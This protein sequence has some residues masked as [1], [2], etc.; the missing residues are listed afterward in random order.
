MQIDFDK[1]SWSIKP[2]GTWLS[3][4]CKDTC[5]PKEFVKGIK[6]KLYIAELKEKRKKRS[7][8]ANAYFWVLCG[9]LAAIL[10]LTTEEIYRQYIHS[11]GN[12]FEIIPMRDDAVEAWIK[13]WSDRGV[14]WICES[15]G[16]SKHEG[17]TNVVCYYGSSV[18]DTKQMSCLIDMVVDDCKTQGIETATPLEIAKLKARWSE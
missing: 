4:R 13:I 1:A 15:L 3:I 18:Y 10:R 9:K 11:I 2:D 6:D 5:K 16:K 8:D 17:Y 12:N 14:G 7:L